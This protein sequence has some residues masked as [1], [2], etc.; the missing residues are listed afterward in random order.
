MGTIAVRDIIRKARIILQ[1]EDAVRWP[2]T[3]MLGWVNDGQRE[4]VLL[5]PNAHSKTVTI[6]LSPGTRQTLPDECILLLDVVRNM[7]TDGQTPSRAIRI[8]LREMLDAQV[9]DW[10]SSRPDR[11]ARVKHYLYSPEMDAKTFFVW[12]PQPEPPE[13]TMQVE[14]MYSASPPEVQIDGA[15]AISDPYSGLLLD[16][17][18]YRA[19]AKDAEHSPVA[20]L[21]A[22]WRETFLSSLSGK[23]HADTA[24][25]PNHAAPAA[26]YMRSSP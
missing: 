10:H 23:N 22:A 18:L 13:Q 16:Y 19:N 6:A 3:E 24:A 2:D 17:V 8:A 12:P 1:D 9:P 4:I 11:E 21:A 25:N 15:I 7:G 14:V 26:P 20:Q 5:K